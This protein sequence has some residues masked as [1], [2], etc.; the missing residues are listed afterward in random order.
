MWSNN[1]S[2][3]MLRFKVKKQ[4][5]AEAFENARKN[6]TSKISHYENKNKGNKRQKIIK[7]DTQ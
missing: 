2:N 5:K 4:S 7:D 6:A 1:P 3:R